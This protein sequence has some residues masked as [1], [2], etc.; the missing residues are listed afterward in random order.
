M[1]IMHCNINPQMERKSIC[2]PRLGA[3]RRHIEYGDRIF[4]R[5]RWGC[6]VLLELSTD[7]VRDYSD[8]L[9][10][11]HRQTR[12]Q[13]GLT[14]LQVRNSTRGWMR[15]SPYMLGGGPSRKG[16]EEGVVAAHSPAPGRRRMLMPFETH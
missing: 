12:E 5:I 6:E 10:E 9:M 13:R 1:E 3:A 15:E 8:L 16:K 7:R 2:N 14:L 4:V 11:I